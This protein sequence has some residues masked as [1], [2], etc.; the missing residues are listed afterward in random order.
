MTVQL[1]L[2]SHL[3]F[4]IAAKDNVDAFF[5][6]MTLALFVRKQIVY[7]NVKVHARTRNEISHKVDEITG[8]PLIPEKHK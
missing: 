4:E 8:D 7:R 2:K 5:V 3:L 1:N 6:F